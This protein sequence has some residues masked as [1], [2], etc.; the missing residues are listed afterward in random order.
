MEQQWRTCSGVKVDVMVFDMAC[1]STITFGRDDRRV[2]IFEQCMAKSV[3][4][5]H[6]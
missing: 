2:K 5:S 3:E 4:H 6:Y 1:K